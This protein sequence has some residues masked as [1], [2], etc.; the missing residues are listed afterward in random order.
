MAPFALRR[1]K[2]LRARLV[3]AN[4]VASGRETYG[5]MPKDRPHAAIAMGRRGCRVRE[6]DSGP[7]P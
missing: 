1:L 3:L 2:M 7:Q 5:G 4:R 6:Q